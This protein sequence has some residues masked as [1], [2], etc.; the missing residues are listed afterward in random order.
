MHSRRIRI[1]RGKFHGVFSLSLIGGSIL[2]GLYAILRENLSAGLLYLL[3]SGLC[4]LTVVYAYCCKC[5]C[6]G[7][8]CSHVLPG[9]LAGML[10]KRKQG[11]YTAADISTVVI[12]LLVI[13]TVPQ[14]WL[15]KASSLL[16][17]FWLFFAAALFEIIF[18]VCSTC[19]NKQCALCRNRDTG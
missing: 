14:L 1:M 17:A 15:A 11:P 12:A 8:C 19:Q 4:A 16:L 5:Q 18:F 2:I 13:I 10:P 3:L 6:R 9:K 7:H